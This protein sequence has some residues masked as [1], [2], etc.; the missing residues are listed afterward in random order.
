MILLQKFVKNSNLF[1]YVWLTMRISTANRNEFCYCADI[2]VIIL[3]ST[4]KACRRKGTVGT[5]N[6][7]VRHE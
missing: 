6:T 1:C 4:F 7:N 3:V 5:Y 2:I